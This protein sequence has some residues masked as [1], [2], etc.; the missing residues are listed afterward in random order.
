MDDNKEKLT[1]MVIPHSGKSTLSLSVPVIVLKII[2]G[3]LAAAV[4]V[5][6][7]FVSNFYL[8]YNRFKADAEKLPA[9]TEDNGT[10]QKQLQFFAEKTRYLEEKMCEIEQLDTD[11]RNLLKDDPALKEC[12]KKGD[13]LS[14]KGVNLPGLSRSVLSSRSGVD[15]ERTIRQLQLLEQRVPLQKQSLEELKDAVI[16]RA[17]RLSHTPSIYPVSGKITSSFG[18]R[19]SPFS[20]RQEFHDGLDIGAPYGTTIVATAAGE[21]TFVGYRAGY[22][23]TVTINHGYGFETSYCHNSSTL[24]KVGQKVKKGQ[25]I[26]R[27]GNSGRST[28][29]HVHYMVKVNGVIKNPANFLK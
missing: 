24:V 4:F 10:L 22:G 19:K 9:I 6:A 2:G 14:N 18:Y 5:G 27:V 16:Q 26:A 20:R 23:T 29:P 15:R 12:V 3:I 17:D 13:N 25:G 28:G 7:I 21:V 8:S 11:L 1:M